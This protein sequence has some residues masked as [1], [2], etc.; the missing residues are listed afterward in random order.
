MV[1][2]RSFNGNMADNCHILKWICKK[3]YNFINQFQSQCFIMYMFLFLSKYICTLPSLFLILSHL[4]LM[5][6]IRDKVHYKMKQSLGAVL[7]IYREKCQTD[8]VHKQLCL[9]FNGLDIG[10]ISSLF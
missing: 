6:I 3:L 8:Q 5:L 4:S 7:T 1:S 2:S 10:Y 9:V